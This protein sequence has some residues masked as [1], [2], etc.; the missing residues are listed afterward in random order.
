VVGTLI[1]GACSSED[2]PRAEPKGGAPKGK[3]PSKVRAKDTKRT[4]AQPPAPLEILKAADAR[5]TEMTFTKPETYPGSRLYSY[6]DGAAETYFARGFREL[7]TADTKWRD[8]EAK[9]ELY[10]VTTA[11]NAKGLFDDH[12]DGKGKKLPAGLGSASWAAKELEGIFYRGLYFCRV[13]IYG[14]DKEAHQLLRT[15]SAAIDKAIPE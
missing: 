7:A 10:R 12:D 8:T 1:I 6:M 4:A 11:D 9:I 13:I 15:L 3:A 2:S 14:N 5:L